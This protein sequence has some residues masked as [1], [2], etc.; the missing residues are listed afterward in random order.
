MI[1]G[2]TNTLGQPIGEPL[3]QWSSRLRPPATP[4]VGR[5]CRIELLNAERHAAQLFA[6]NAHDR[7][8]RN[9]T[10]LGY[11]P[12]NDVESYRAWVERVAAA[13]DPLFHAIIDSSTGAA[14]GVASLMR[15]D[16]D[17]GVI[18]VGHINY[19]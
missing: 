4:L 11:G 2:R 7:D 8:G 16:P 9:W 17:N 6:A 5:S 3:R 19:S 12:F 13:D 1:V 15:I 14:V 18:E 10:Y